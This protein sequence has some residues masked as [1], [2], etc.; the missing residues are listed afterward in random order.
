MPSP[1]TG[2]EGGGPFIPPR[3]PG[4]APSAFSPTPPP[5]SADEGSFLAYHARLIQV[6]QSAYTN[7][8]VEDS[9]GRNALHCL[10]EAML[11]QPSTN[12]NRA[13]PLTGRPNLKRKQTPQPFPNISA[14]AAAG[15]A[16]PPSA[17][18]P[19]PTRKRKQPPSTLSVT[20][21]APSG[22]SAAPP[23][24]SAPPPPDN[25][26]LSRLR[27]L[28]SLL[29]PASPLQPPRIDINHY[30]RSGLTPLMAFILFL[31]DSADDKSKTLL[32]VLE[33]L[34]RHGARLEARNRL[35]ETALL[36]AAR[37]GRKVALTT[38]LEHG[39]NVHARDVWGRGVLEIVDRTVRRRGAGDVALYARL[40][41]VRVLLTGR[42]EWG[43]LSTE[44][45]G[46]RGAVGREWMMRGVVE[47]AL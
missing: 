11:H 45:E 12:P 41:A 14:A 42:R 9:A 25:P 33:T 6:I 35:G 7:P 43:V 5:S 21:P 8:D 4:V 47:G 1:H 24:P 39:A 38:L 31:P 46:A 10:A 37:L 15:A 17:P 13:T 16:A 19:A 23:A 2:P 22:S 28:E 30:S 29:L 32:A 27:H 26:I 20:T 34:I 44:G 36:M 3:Q 18:V 40:E